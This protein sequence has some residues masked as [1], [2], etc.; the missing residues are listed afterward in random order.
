MEG[1]KDGADNALDTVKIPVEAW[2][3]EYV[4]L[5]IASVSFFNA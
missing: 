4:L 5:L 3:I 1:P 2:L